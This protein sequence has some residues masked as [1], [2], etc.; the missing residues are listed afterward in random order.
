[1]I[2]PFQ[3]V[4]E[5]LRGVMDWTGEKARRIV[6]PMNQEMKEMEKPL[7]SMRGVALRK[8]NAMLLPD[9][10]WEIR[11][12]QN[13]AILGANGSGKSVLA[14]AVKGDVPVVR[15]ELVR[16][17][18][19]AAVERIGCLSF[20]LLEELLLREDRFEYARFFSGGGHAL[21]AGE[22]L[23]IDAGDST[24]AQN[25]DDVMGIRPLLN[26]SI[27]AL[28]N[29]E[30]RK[31]LITRALLSSPKMLILDE[32]FAGLDVES[33]QS[34]ARAITDLMEKGTQII[35]V[36][37]RPEEIV[38][39][40]SHVL[41]I[42][43]GRVTKAGR[44]EEVMTLEAMKSV[45]AGTARLPSLPRPIPA[46]ANV[47]R[48]SADVLIEM[49]NVHV[50]YGEVTVLDRLTWSVRRGERWAVVGPNGSG[51]TT[52]L[53][54]ITGDNLQVY[55]N[56]VSLFGHKRGEGESIWDIRRRLGLVSPE[57]QLRY[58]K[59]VRVQE[60]VLSGFFDSIGLYRKVSAEQT[61]LAEQWLACIGM[62][63]YA[64]RPFNHLSYGERRLILIARA[65]VKSPEL[66]ILDEPCQ[67]LDRSNREMVLALMEEI[68]RKTS[69]TMLYVTHRESE[70]I[71]CIQ[72]VLRLGGERREIRA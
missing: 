11:T 10:F 15:G 67:G 21:T 26:R 52:L 72:H 3:M 4:P 17:S 27:R 16:H 43:D 68:G 58:R 54:L 30:M 40:I 59:P 37:Q 41:L 23:G 33:R 63:E 49:R 29:G 12:G 1:M 19:D 65:M 39:G 20:E 13:W 9:T 8:G 51:K 62:T 36:T 46:S 45:S 42:R 66:L 60:V 38:T 61:D 57:L 6:Q 55:A 7:I 35:L 5:T 31:V 2:L 56:D 70:M 44:R 71:P 24:A 47:S 69:T 25:F 64:E 48:S 28:S 18:P 50:A 53:S 32:P 14:R 34:L 22:L